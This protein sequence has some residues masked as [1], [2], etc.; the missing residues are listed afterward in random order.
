MVAREVS[1]LQRTRASITG[2]LICLVVFRVG[3]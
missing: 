2:Q 3:V 1:I